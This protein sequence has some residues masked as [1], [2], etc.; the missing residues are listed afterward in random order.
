MEQSERL[1]EQERLFA[2]QRHNIIYT[3]LNANGLRDEE[4]YDVVALGYLRAV[5]RYHREEKLQQYRFSAIAWQAMRTNA[6]NKKRADRIRGAVI[7]CSL[8]ELTDDGTEYGEF[9]RD[10]KDSF[11]ELEE[12]ENLHQILIKVMPAL[13][14]R[15]QEH[16]IK[17][18]N[19][20]K[21]TEIMKEQRISVRE[22][23]KD[24][25][26]VETTVRG[27]IPDFIGGGYLIYG[28]AGCH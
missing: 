5:K 9:I 15:Q 18:L 25:K 24:R 22:Y 6:G 4:F 1:T 27:A 13:T 23:H 3:F 21:P 14:K 11:W 12:E 16:L 19:G 10:T 26:I 7:A 2:E 17:T 28:Q 8:N 20:Y